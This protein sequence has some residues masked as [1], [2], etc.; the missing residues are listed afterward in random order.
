MFYDLKAEKHCTAYDVRPQVCKDYPRAPADLFDT[1]NCGFFFVDEKG[2]K[3]D[4]YM[5]RRTRLRLIRAI[6]KLKKQNV[7]ENKK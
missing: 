6:N 3:I 4:G 2:R 7:K 5:D 1:P